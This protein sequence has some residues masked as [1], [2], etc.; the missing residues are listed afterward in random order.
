MEQQA[1]DP[2]LW[3]SRER[4]QQLTRDLSSLKNSVAQWEDLERDVFSTLELARELVSERD[5]ELEAEI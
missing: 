1:Q 4:G 2:G 5:A 3:E